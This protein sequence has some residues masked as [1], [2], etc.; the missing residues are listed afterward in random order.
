[1]ELFIPWSSLVGGVLLGISAS[2]LLVFS[3]KIAGISGIVGG[4]ISPRHGHW[5]WRLAF[6]IGMV[7]SAYFSQLFG[8]ELPTLEEANTY[9]IIASGLLVGF[10]TALGNGCTSGH[11]IVGMGRLSKRSIVATLTFMAVA[12]LVVLAQRLVGNA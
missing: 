3:G 4:L 10:G 11:G 8:L 5:L 2:L 12:M 6:V 9:L 1:M 7:L